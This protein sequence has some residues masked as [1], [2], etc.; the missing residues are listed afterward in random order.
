MAKVAVPAPAAVPASKTSTTSPL[1]RR[2]Q[3][4]SV[5]R[6]HVLL[7][8]SAMAI[9]IPLPGALAEAAVQVR[10]IRKLAALYD[11][12]FD[13][14]RTQT[15]LAAVLGALS[16]GWMAGRLLRFAASSTWI[17]P[18]WPGAALTGGLCYLI[19]R[20]FIGHFENGGS[21]EDARPEDAAA[22]LRSSLKD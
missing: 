6:D 14:S 11:V 17:L 1:V 2:V 22:L 15:F 3:A 18:F 12:Q 19:G 5:V 4:E 21:L 20:F 7:S 13:E 16:A 9:P 8:A 10:M